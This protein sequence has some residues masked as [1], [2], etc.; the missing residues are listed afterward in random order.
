MLH[1]D[2]NDMILLIEKSENTADEKAEML[3]MWQENE[4]KEAIPHPDYLE[5]AFK[6]GASMK[7]KGIKWINLL[8]PNRTLIHHS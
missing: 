7:L 5:I 2:N 6:N 1:I 8:F 3:K 4:E